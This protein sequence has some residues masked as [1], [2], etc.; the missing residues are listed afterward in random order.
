MQFMHDVINMD[1]SYKAQESFIV[2]DKL[3]FPKII[4]STKLYVIYSIKYKKLCRI[5]NMLN[6]V[7]L[8]LQSKHQLWR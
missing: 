7:N 8:L 1:V 3:L 5:H 4:N 6:N 2:Y